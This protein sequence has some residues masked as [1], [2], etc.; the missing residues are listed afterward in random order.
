MVLAQGKGSI[1]MCDLKNEKILITTSSF[2]SLDARPIE[3]LIGTGAQ[4][5]NNPYKRRLTKEEVM[6][7]LSEGF[8]GLI[9]GLEPLDRDVLSSSTLKVV[10][11]C[12][13][14]VSNVDLEAAIDLGIEVKTTPDAPVESVAELTLCGIL[15]V[16]RRLPKMSAALHNRAWNKEIGSLLQNKTV[17]IIGYGRI[18]RRLK[19]L[20]MPFQVNIVAVD[21]CYGGEDPDV[22]SK[23]LTEALVQADIISIHS[24]GEECIIG[25]NEIDIVKDGVVLVNMARGLVVDEVAIAEGLDKGK[26]KG[27]YLDVFDEE[28]YS[29]I[30]TE[31]DNVVLSPHVGS[32]TKEC[33][34]E[35]EMESVENLIA[36]MK[37]RIT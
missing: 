24:S 26:I 37:E 29:G 19:E 33:R 13:S 35:M 3:K 25:K 7:L 9:A 14:G 17:L 2:S 20:L 11:R 4:V 31:Y 5:I 8:S 21:P 27:V 22:E 15:S 12:G 10:S 28:P 16:L 32:Y 34:F 1:N 23:K 6:G 18:G 30:L 36:S